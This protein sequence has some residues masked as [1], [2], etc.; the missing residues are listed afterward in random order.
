MTAVRHLVAGKFSMRIVSSR[1][2]LISKQI[3]LLHV[4]YD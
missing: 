3:F 1:S 4:C 2:N